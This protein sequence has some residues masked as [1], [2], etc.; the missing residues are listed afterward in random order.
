[1]SPRSHL[2]KYVIPIGSFIATKKLANHRLLARLDNKKDYL[3]RAASF[4]RIANLAGAAGVSKR[5]PISE[6]VLGRLSLSEIPSVSKTLLIET[7]P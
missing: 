5:H 1:V 2:L 4:L 3:S 6:R 7:P